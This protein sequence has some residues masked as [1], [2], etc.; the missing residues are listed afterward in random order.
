[1][2]SSATYTRKWQY[3][4]ATDG[5]PPVPGESGV[6]TVTRLDALTKAGPLE[7]YR[8]LI[9]TGQNATTNMSGVKWN[10]TQIP[11]SLRHEYRDLRFVNLVKGSKVVLQGNLLSLGFPVGIPTL[12][13]TDISAR[14]LA[15][16]RYYSNVASIQTK[17]KGMVFTGELRESLSMIRHPARA[18][19]NGISGYLGFLR[20]NAGRV[21]KRHRPSFVRKTWLEYAFG[22]RPL[23]A[24]IDN[25][26]DAFYSSKWAHPIFE[27]V[28]GTGR[29][30]STS[31]SDTSVID[32]GAL[33]DVTFR[34]WA[35]EE[36][37]YKYFGI[38]H[39]IGNGVSNS[40]SAGF[41][42]AEFVPTVWELIPYSFLVDYF[43]NIG[44]IV[45]SWSYRFLVNGF[46]SVTNR[47][48]YQQ[49]LV[50]IGYKWRM[51]DPWYSH[52]QTGS[53]GAASYDVT[54]FARSRDAVLSIPS[55]ELKVPGRWDQWV[56]IA[57][58]TAQLKVARKA[59]AR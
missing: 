47:R 5:G 42:P 40:H 49:N 17:F 32:V 33:H 2:A 44:N 46:T 53:P 22:W 48:V 20:K 6:T 7:N 10:I 12:G 16:T 9:A 26:I 50:D 34:T 31:L 39:N 23:I 14:N 11:A 59:L 21:A 58:L 13:L 28:K 36:V 55:L 24:D 43:T 51:I 1:M 29:E 4:V 56:S 18:L 37:F 30:E 19:R 3:T 35:K 57:A 38:H 8:R 52:S 54:Q 25:A 41:N 45:S 15:L 27:M